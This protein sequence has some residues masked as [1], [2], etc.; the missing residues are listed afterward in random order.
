MG[1]SSMTCCQ[2]ENDNA[3]TWV[4]LENK[5]GGGH[6]PMLISSDSKRLLKPM[7]Q[8]DRST[9]EV[10]AY[11]ELMLQPI[12]PFI[13]RLHGSRYVDGENYME[14]DSAYAGISSPH[15]T[16][17]VKIGVKTWED[18]ADPEKIAK[19]MAQQE[20]LAKST[21]KDGFRCC[22]IQAG[23]LHL[24]AQDV[25]KRQG[26]A[27]EEFTDWLLSSFFSTWPGYSA[28]P[29]GLIG[30]CAPDPSPENQ[31]DWNAAR[32]VLQQLRVLFAAAQLGYGGDLRGSSVLFVREMRIG[33]SWCFKLIDLAHYSRREGGRPDDNF[34]SGL[35]NLL[36]TWEAFCESAPRDV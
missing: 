11:K 2:T 7:D 24:R 8:G 10:E 19:M 25:R 34:C 26:V 17:D 5:I 1:A 29:E 35:Q 32:Q 27:A 15:A 28:M 13:C 3:P 31:V 30:T 12:G 22:G 14:L 6:A 16:L 23:H 21:A 4:V 36:K 20:L 9:R 33:G 18:D